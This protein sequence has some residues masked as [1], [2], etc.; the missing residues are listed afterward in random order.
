MGKKFFFF[1]NNDRILDIV[2]FKGKK[3]CFQNSYIY[4][5]TTSISLQN[6]KLF[7]TE[8]EMLMFLHDAY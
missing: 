6:I 1:L 4:I 5:E 8:C 2:C 7:E 3:I